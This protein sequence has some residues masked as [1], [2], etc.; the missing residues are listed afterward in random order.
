MS[1]QSWRDPEGGLAQVKM[2][3]IH[4]HIPSHPA[5]QSAPEVYNIFARKEGV[6]NAGRPMHPQPACK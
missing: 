5:T 3:H 4:R 6:G 1:V 2:S